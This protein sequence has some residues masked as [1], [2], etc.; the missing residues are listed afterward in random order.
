MSDPAQERPGPP[1]FIVGTTVRSGT[2]FLSDLLAVHPDCTRTTRI[3]EDRVMMDAGLLDAYVE[4][5]YQRWPDKWDV[6]DAFKARLMHELGDAIVRSLAATASEPCGRLVTKTPSVINLRHFP[7]LFPEASLLLVVRDGRAVVESWT[8]TF[9]ISFERAARRWAEA[10]RV[11]VAFD[12]DHRSSGLRYTIVRYEDL[13][14]TQEATLR[15]ILATCGL[16]AERYDFDAAHRIPVR[17]SSALRGD[18]DRVHWDTIDRTPEFKP[19][20]RFAHWDA[21]THARFNEIAGSALESVGY[22]LRSAAA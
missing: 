11:L 20:E 21:A 1:I 15:R 22:E 19:L 14:A 5:L 7:R 9:K 17:G 4:A 3:H 2:N 18:S 8:H 16:A 10:V 6:P 12:D 13:F